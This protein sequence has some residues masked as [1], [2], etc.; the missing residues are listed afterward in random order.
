MLT[1]Q[2]VPYSKID[3]LPSE[4]RVNRLLDIILDNKIILLQGKLRKEEEA[5]LIEKTMEQIG[6]SDD[7]NF[8]GIELSTID[9]EKVRNQKLMSHI[10]FAF[11]SMLLGDRQGMTIVGPASIVKEIK[12]DPEKIELFLDGM[13]KSEEKSSSSVSAATSKKIA[14]R[15][16][17]SKRKK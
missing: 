4:E 17:V 7:N 8:K 12:K 16:K 6:K 1:I 10:R 5:M 3:A 9:S 11:L 13:N 2:Y 15:K 14:K